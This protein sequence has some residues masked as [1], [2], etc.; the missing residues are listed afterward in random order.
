MQGCLRA[1]GAAGVR[2]RAGGRWGGEGEAYLGAGGALLH[3]PA[4]RQRRIA[5]RWL[6]HGRSVV[7]RGIWAAG[8]QR[9]GR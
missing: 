4:E 3:V 6:S 5:Q 7:T 1:H 9:T 8:R 2:R